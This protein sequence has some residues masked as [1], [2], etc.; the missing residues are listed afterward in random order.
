MLICELLEFIDDVVDELGSREHIDYVHKI[1]AEGTGADKQLAVF[2]QT[3]DLTRVVD[4]IT[5]EFTKGL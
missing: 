1:M 3:N 5:S 4:F 2:E